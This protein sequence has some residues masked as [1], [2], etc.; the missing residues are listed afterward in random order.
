MLESF[1]FLP[2]NAMMSDELYFAKDDREVATFRSST[3]NIFSSTI[4]VMFSTESDRILLFF[5]RIINK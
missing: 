3:A 5:I 4:L 1:E 2:Q